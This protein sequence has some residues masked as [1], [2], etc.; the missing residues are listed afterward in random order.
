MDNKQIFI[1]G[2]SRGI[3]RAIAL[4]F[5]VNGWDVL[6]CSRQEKNVEAFKSELRQVNAKI[7]VYGE[8]VDLSQ[9][10]QAKEFAEKLAQRFPKIE[11]LVNNAGSFIQG[12]ISDSNQ[13]LLISQLNTN[14]MS[15]YWLSR[16]IIENMK[17]N[18]LGT[19]FNISSIAG[20][21]AYAQGGAYSIS[22]F[23]L[24]GF[25]KSLRSELRNDN[26][27]VTAIHPGAIYTD[28]WKTSGVEETRIMPVEDIGKLIYSIQSLDQRTV[29][30]DIILR[31]ILGDL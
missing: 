29:V 31:P 16:P 10:N 15:A 20:L 4:N 24:N 18:Q 23:A 11:V 2:A 27:R 30:E 21:Q 22:K 8:V 6:F 13:D 12:D 26:I 28:S 17:I 14:L 5:A 25:S 9:E 7:N 3:G 19:I 1:S